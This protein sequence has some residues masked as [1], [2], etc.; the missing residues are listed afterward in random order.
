MRAGTAV[1]AELHRAALNELAAR[2]GD[3]RCFV[4]TALWGSADPRTQALRTWRDCWLLK[5]RWGAAATWLYYRLSPSLVN[6]VARAPR[7]RALLNVTLSAFA[8][9]VASRPD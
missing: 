7:L 8:K 9:R 6:I 3:D 1:H 2:A 5:R 4:A